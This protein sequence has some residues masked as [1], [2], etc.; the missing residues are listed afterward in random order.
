M[1]Y[2]VMALYDTKAR[3]FRTPFFV[4]HVDVGLRA[5]RGAVNQVGHELGQYASDFLAYHLGDFDDERGFFDQLPQPVNLG[6]IAALKEV[7]LTVT[8][9]KEPQA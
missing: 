2:K 6:C 1:I 5:V 8:A 7:S 9:P 4:A 3:A